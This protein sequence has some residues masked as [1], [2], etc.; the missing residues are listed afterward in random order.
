M[1]FSNLLAG[2]RSKQSSWKAPSR[3]LAIDPGETV[4]H[5]LFVDGFFVDCGQVVAKENP[6]QAI[7]NLIELMNPTHIVAEDYKVYSTKTESHAW[8]S[9]FTPRMLGMIELLGYQRNIQ[10]HYQMAAVVK[11]F[12]NAA[13]LQEWNFYKPGKRHADDA[14]KHGTYFLL[15]HDRKRD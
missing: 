5:A 4:G 1:H 11:Q 7:E 12:C 8:S 14:I 3:L 15:F 2:I 13:K 10:V 9:L 6:A